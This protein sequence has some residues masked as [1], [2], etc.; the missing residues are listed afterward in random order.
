MTI[1]DVHNVNVASTPLSFLLSRARGIVAQSARASVVNSQCAE[2]RGRSARSPGE[3]H[4]HHI[5]IGSVV[6]SASGK[7]ATSAC[8][9]SYTNNLADLLD[10]SGAWE[11]SKEGGRDSSA[12]WHSVAHFKRIPRWQM[13]AWNRG[14]DDV[15]AGDDRS[16][17]GTLKSEAGIQ[18]KGTDGVLVECPSDWVDGC[19]GRAR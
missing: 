10:L 9:T 5:K 1:A 7:K 19:A 11:D 15:V 4:F 13:R 17:R 6:E 14:I 3:L 12:G 2:C 8:V 18:W 16:C